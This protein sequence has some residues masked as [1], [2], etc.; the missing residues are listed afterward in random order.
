MG[1][2]FE[3]ADNRKHTHEVLGSGVEQ[4]SEPDA[5]QEILEVEIEGLGEDASAL[6]E[7][8]DNVDTSRLT[9]EQA[10]LFERVKEFSLGLIDKVEA[11]AIR[12]ERITAVALLAAS[13]ASMYMLSQSL[14]SYGS[15][16]PH[17]TA[18]S[19]Y[20]FTPN[21]GELMSATSNYLAA[22]QVVALVAS[23]FSALGSFIWLADTIE[24]N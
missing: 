4:V 3:S 10:T 15:F 2:S 19:D 8:M 21:P 24:K 23:A 9:P 6:R 17:F 14:N 1:H 7:A 5:Q 22:S 18:F 13:V 12:H 20:H 11:F 16:T